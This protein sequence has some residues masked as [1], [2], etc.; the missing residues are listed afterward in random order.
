MNI[1]IAKV[2]S[3]QITPKEWIG[4]LIS[5]ASVF[6]GAYFAYRFNNVQEKHKDKKQLATAYEALSNQIALSLNNIY[7]AKSICIELC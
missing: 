4:Y 6:L 2:I 7:R 1:D 3:E 5:F